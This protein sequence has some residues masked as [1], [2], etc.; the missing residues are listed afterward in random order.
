MHTQYATIAILCSLLSGSAIAGT[1]ILL[2]FDELQGSGTPW[3]GENYS[4]YG[5]V[6]ST[7]LG[8]ELRAYGNGTGT[9]GNNFIYGSTSGSAN[10]QVRAVFDNGVN[11]VGFSVIDSA[12]PDQTWTIQIFDINSELLDTLEGTGGSAD[13]KDPYIEFARDSFD[14]YEV[15]FSPS[16]DFEGIDNFRYTVVPAPGTACVFLSFA[17]LARRRRC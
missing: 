16:S 14:I 8:A 4:Q 17:A 3:S 15:V 12:P 9:Y 10:A 6:F 13:G 1:T 2:K 5:V 7:S 11:N